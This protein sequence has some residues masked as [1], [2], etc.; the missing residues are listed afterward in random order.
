[1][2]VWVTLWTKPGTCHLLSEA[3]LIQAQMRLSM[4]LSTEQADDGCDVG[5]TGCGEVLGGHLERDPSPSWPRF[6][7][8]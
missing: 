3:V 5:G 7:H 8:L 2:S 1:M 6:L 4:R